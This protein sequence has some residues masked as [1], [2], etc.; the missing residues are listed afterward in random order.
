M[1]NIYITSKAYALKWI[2]RK[3]FILFVAQIRRAELAKQIWS[4]KIAFN[5][6][7]PIKLSGY[8]SVILQTKTCVSM[9]SLIVH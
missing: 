8:K 9:M 2:P 5:M 1:T 3:T 4:L 7:P 6:M